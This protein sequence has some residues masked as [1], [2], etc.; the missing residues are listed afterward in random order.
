MEWQSWKWFQDVL[1]SLFE[2]DPSLTSF[3]FMLNN[4][5]ASRHAGL[6]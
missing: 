1:D 4:R 5:T 6:R 2:D 3:L